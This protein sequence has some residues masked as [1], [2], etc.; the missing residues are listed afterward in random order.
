[1]AY[2]ERPA[3][4][5]RDLLRKKRGVTEKKMFG[6]LAFMSRGDMSVGVID[7]RLMVRVGPDAYDR[8]LSRRHVRP[9]DFTGQPL[10]GFVYVEPAGIRTRA[11]LSSW[12]DKGLDFAASLPVKKSNKKR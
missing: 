7:D 4:R 5:V 3:E 2:D 8:A 10:T 12:L 9:M 11:Q 6:G 1:M